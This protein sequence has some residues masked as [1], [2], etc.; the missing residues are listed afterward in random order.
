MGT[1]DRTLIR[2]IVTRAEV[3]M[4]Q[5]KQEFQK[6]FGQSLEAFIRVTSLFCFTHRVYQDFVQFKYVLTDLAGNVISLQTV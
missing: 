1:D 4:V 5:I 3:D 6:Q 2:L